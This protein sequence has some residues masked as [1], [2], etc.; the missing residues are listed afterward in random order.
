MCLRI[1]GWFPHCC[2][3]AL[4]PDS[5]QQIMSNENKK[6]NREGSAKHEP[7]LIGQIWSNRLANGNDDFTVAYRQHLINSRKEVVAL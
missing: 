7:R 1:A 4:T 3:A 2:R 5:L 6:R